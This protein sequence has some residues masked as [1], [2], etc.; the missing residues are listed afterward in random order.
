[1]PATP[2]VAPPAQ[3]G[4]GSTSNDDRAGFALTVPEQTGAKG[5]WADVFWS[6]SPTSVHTYETSRQAPPEPN[7]PLPSWWERKED[8]RLENGLRYYSRFSSGFAYE[9]AGWQGAPATPEER[10][11]R[12]G[13]W[14]D[15]RA[16]MRAAMEAA[17][18]PAMRLDRFDQCGAACFILV[19][20][21]TG[22]VKRISNKCRDRH[23]KPCSIERANLYAANVK[24]RLNEYKG[25]TERR[26]RFVT[27]TLRSSDDPLPKQF[28]RWMECFTKLRRL[29][30]CNLKRRKLR[31]WWAT[32]VVGGCYFLEATLSEDTG[33][34]HVHA[35]LIIEGNYLPQHELSA[36]WR[37]VTG[38]SDVVDVRQLSGVDDV[39]AEVSKYTAKGAGAKLAAGGDKL[40]EWIIGTKSLRL[41]STFGTWRGF[42]LAAPVDE[43]DPSQWV[44]VGRE[45]D[46][47]AKAALGDAWAR[48]IVTALERERN[49]PQ[50]S[51]R[52]PPRNL[53]L[54]A[55]EPA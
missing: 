35:H 6:A 7:G 51:R 1:M 23:C 44:N 26:F 15:E 5:G 14:A 45:D 55:T 36:V 3:A 8:E 12:H 41:C 37:L 24:K 21:H 53:Q 32:F 11:R 25:R 30:L 43:F 27:L 29:R 49:N 18:L 52:P 47:R 2:P 31:N 33:R 9:R 20:R 16:A 28:R 10:D 38:D 4:S 42:R 34:W 46:I 19:K 22:D 40:A 39:A 54:F 48:G 17:G 13:F 50:H